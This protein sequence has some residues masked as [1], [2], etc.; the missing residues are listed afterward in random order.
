MSAEQYDG[1]RQIGL[2]AH[3]F[4]KGHWIDIVVYVEIGAQNHPRCLKNMGFVVAKGPR[5]FGGTLSSC[6]DELLFDGLDPEAGGLV[7][8]VG[9]ECD[10]GPPGVNGAPAFRDFAIEVGNDGDEEV[11]WVRAPVFFEQA[12]H[13]PMEETYR[14]LQNSQDIFAAKGPA[15]LQHD[16]VLLLDANASEFTQHVQAVR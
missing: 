1:C 6:D 2:Q 4:A 5:L 8:Q 16:V 14:K 13:G 3:F 10:E 9:N 7:R 12:H 11:G 15:V